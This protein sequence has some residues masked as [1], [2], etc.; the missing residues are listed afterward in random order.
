MKQPNRHQLRPAPGLDPTGDKPLS[1]RSN[2]VPAQPGQTRP[3]AVRQDAEPATGR[4]VWGNRPDDAILAALAP[5]EIPSQVVPPRK[6]TMVQGGNR[7]LTRPLAVTWREVSPWLRSGMRRSAL[8][9]RRALRMSVGM[10]VL[11]ALI[12]GVVGTGLAGLVDYFYVR[13]LATNGLEALQRVPDDLGLGAHSTH[14]LVTAAQ[15]TQ[16]QGDLDTALRDFQTLHDKLANPDP[17]LQAASRSGRVAADLRSGYLLSSVAIDGVHIT[18]AMFDSLVAVA[19]VVSSSPVTGGTSGSDA[20]TGLTTTD[21]AT[22]QANFT[23]ALPFI[24]DIIT[25][26][27]TTTPGELLAALSA[28]QRAKVAPLLRLVPQLPALL[29]VMDR[30]FAA[31]P[32]ILGIGQPAA[33]LFITMDPSEMRAS[34]GFQGN[35]AVVGVNGG[36]MGNISLQD[37]YLLDKPYDATA[38]GSQDVPPDSYL[39][40]WPHAFLPWG[41]RDANLS[42]DFPTSAGYDLSELSLENGAA[43]P[44][45][46]ASGKVTGHRPVT[47]TG[48]IAMQPEVIKQLLRI[49]GSIRIG[50]PYDVTVTADNLEQ[51]IHYFQLT[52]AGRTKGGDV[53]SGDQSLSSAN[54]RFTAL[55]A[56]GLEDRVKTMGRDKLF[57]F[58]GTV[59]NDLHTKDIQLSFTDPGAE[60][61]LRHYQISS[62]VYTGTADGLLITSTNI[63][64]N[65]ASQYLREQVHDTIQLDSA[66]GATHTMTINYVWNPLPIINGTNPDEVYSVLYNADHTNNYGLYYRQY[67]RIYTGLHPHVLNAQGWQFGG[68]ET[69]VSDI[70]DRGMIGTHY[71]IQGDA[72]TTPVTWTVPSTQLSWYVPQAY[73]PGSNYI[74]H[75]QHQ[76]GDAPS[77]DVTILPPACASTA[78]LHFTANSLTIDTLLTLATPGC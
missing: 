75:L 37:V 42:A 14:H 39:N 66:G 63:S 17:I 29:P 54:K 36:R 46:D 77:V 65:K 40:W 51:Q 60:D 7:A 34:G 10:L 31:A 71:I 27:Q 50:A 6:Q 12:T 16:A 13:G 15:R 53:G 8:P 57:A 5:P 24:N 74:L 64:G 78:P 18:Q 26:L 58:V 47:M 1:N 59:L 76:A 67:V 45:L 72:T 20:G 35:Y 52:N 30:F 33:Y 41:L 49:A 28:S 73:A 43:V 56:R 70:A 55:L 3:R 62:E 69:T 2:A 22:I 19:N 38:A 21:L 48:V 25:R 9:S 44:V 11:I 32:A 68:Y 23:S 4:T 61:F